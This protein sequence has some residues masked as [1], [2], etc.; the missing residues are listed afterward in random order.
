VR[1]PLVGM[2]SGDVEDGKFRVDLSGSL[3]D[4]PAIDPAPQID[5]GNKR[6]ILVLVSFE[7]GYRFF[8]GRRD[9]RFKTAISKSV[10]ND[11]LNRWVVFNNQDNRLIFQYS[12]S[13][14]YPAPNTLRG[15]RGF[16]PEEST[17]VNLG[18]SVPHSVVLPRTKRDHC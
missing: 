2:C 8:A 12:N 10:F 9:S 5:V 14:Y 13:P 16:V 1:G 11:D 18:A 15:S 6:A 7:K 3:R 4:F 17:K